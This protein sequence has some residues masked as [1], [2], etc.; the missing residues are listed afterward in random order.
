[1]KVLKVLTLGETMALLDPEGDGRPTAGTQFVLRVAGAESNVAIGLRR[2]GVDTSWVSRLGRDVL[3]DVVHSTLAAEGVDV[4]WVARDGA[5]PTGV[6][7]KWRESGRSHVTYYRRGSAA[8][9]L[10]PGDLPDEALDGVALV[11][12]TGITMALS[13]SARELVADVAARAARRG[14]TV[15]FDPNWRPAL[16][17]SSADAAAAHRDV[18]SNVDWYLCGSEEGRTLWGTESDEETIDAVRA[19]GAGDAVVRIGARGAVVR[20]AGAL[21]EVPPPRV[22]EVR[23]EIGAGDAFAAGFAYGLLHGWR[24]DDCAASG[25]VVAAA[26]LAGTGDWETLPHLADV[27]DRLRAA[28]EGGR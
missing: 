8:S 21:R 4:R 19:A 28:T 15:L 1:M 3:G 27:A 20:V 12:L 11:H 16:W 10:A 23:D 18:L 2:L 22:V 7:L 24:P 9:R 26:A 13:G 6:F 5:A 25:N 17:S 14:I